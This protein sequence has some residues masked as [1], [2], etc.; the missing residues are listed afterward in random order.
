MSQQ[1][2]Q[3]RAFALLQWSAI[4][5][6]ICLVIFNIPYQALR[7]Q[8]TTKTLTQADWERVHTLTMTA[9]SE[10]YNLRFAEAE[11]RCNEVIQLAPTDP[12]GHFFKSSLSYY[13]YL[14][15]RDKADYERF[16]ALSQRAIQVSENI[17]KYNEKDSKALFYLGGTLGYRGIAFQNNGDM[18][19]AAFEGKKGYDKLKEAVELDP[20]NVDAQMGLGLFNYL[21]S[22]AP[23]F[24]RPALKLA[25]L[26]GDRMAGLKYLSNAATNG[27]YAKTE[28]Q[29]AL[30]NILRTDF[31]QQYDRSAQLLQTLIAQYPNNDFFQSILADVLL[32]NLRKADKA[33]ELY[34]RIISKGA[35]ANTVAY[36]RAMLRFG[37]TQMYKN[38]LSDATQWFQKCIAHSADSLQVRDANFNCGVCTEIQGNRSA[39]VGY[40]QR[41][42]GVLRSVELLKAPLTPPEIMVEKQTFSF[43]AGD[44]EAALMVG[45]EIQRMPGMADEVKSRALYVQ[46]RTLFE[47]G[48]YAK[49]EE[50]FGAASVLTVTKTLW[51]P[52]NVR[53]RLGLTQ[54]KLGKKSDAKFSF[55]AALTFENYPN[56]EFTKRLIHKELSRLKS[57]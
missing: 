31:E 7:A 14:I 57:S 29:F 22:Q 52:A 53:Y 15:Y 35:L 26:S 34:Q 30:A 42:T 45:E 37:M 12:R 39:A 20:T 49:A 18:L 25:G 2:P 19:K 1:S 33:A 4:T 54:L 46:G 9:I 40:Y 11:Q 43:N 21:I 13:R 56:E 50:R 55:E 10:M 17:L 51:L 47:R 44:Y 23:S 3:F 41:S 32:F 24:V 36:G 28:A 48:E 8:T 27:L 16:L 38:R 5:I 6:L